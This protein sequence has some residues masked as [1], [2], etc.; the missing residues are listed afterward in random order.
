MPTLVE[1]LRGATKLAVE[2]TK[3]VTSLVQ[4]MHTAIGGGPQLLG[5]PFD[6]LLR[7]LSAPT[8]ETIR[9]VAGVVGTGLDLALQALEPLIQRAGADRGF[10]LAVLNGVMGDYLAATHNPLAIEPC[11][12][13]AGQPLE[14]TKEALA[15]KF[16]TPGARLLVLVHGSSAD[17]STWRRNGHD[18]GE[19]L[20]AGGLV[21]IYA[22]YNSGLH[23]SENGRTLSA[24]L[25]RLVEAWP[26]PVQSI[27][28]LAHSMGGLVCRSALLAAE[29]EGRAWRRRVRTLVTL[30][31]PHHGAP[32]ERGGNW[33]EALLGIHRY[34]APL[35]SLAR[36]RSA[37]VTDL[38][39][40]FVLDEHWQGTD[41]FARTD[42][43]R[44]RLALPSGVACCAV[45]G[46]TSPA[47]TADAAGDGLVPVD[48][49][50][51][52][53]VDPKLA[54]AFASE[55]VAWGCSHLDLLDNPVVS[56]KLREWL[57]P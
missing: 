39:Y 53:H 44:E 50:L 17:D 51:G 43:P 14:L 26:G 56:E 40:G 13:V 15:A 10:L 9:G 3:S 31:T 7:L 37:G 34:S 42:D 8:Y 48:S 1:Q 5:R 16:P 46:S 30:G 25:E 18:H 55:L 23:V 4:E 36:L 6:E 57:L 52:H 54:L 38:R 24:L 45:A 22:R 28:L 49:A 32:L 11:L 27:D 47:H 20:A 41:R 21:P 12:C 33:L 35:A 29:A 19:A 2:A